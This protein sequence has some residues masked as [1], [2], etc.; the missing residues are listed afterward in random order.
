MA[1]LI[2]IFSAGK[3]VDLFYVIAEPKYQETI[4][5][6]LASNGCTADFL[7]VSNSMDKAKHIVNKVFN[8]LKIKVPSLFRPVGPL[9]L[10]EFLE[11]LMARDFISTVC[12]TPE[13]RRKI[14]EK[15]TV[16]GQADTTTM[17]DP[18]SPA[19]DS[20]FDDDVVNEIARLENS[21]NALDHSIMNQPILDAINKVNANL[22]AQNRLMKDVMGEVK[23]LKQ[24][25]REI[26]VVQEKQEFILQGIQAKLQIEPTIWCHF[27]KI[28]SHNFQECKLK[29][30]CIFCA[31]EFHSADECIWKLM[32]CS[33]CGEQGHSNQVHHVKEPALRERI[34]MCHGKRKFSFR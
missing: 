26:K 27:C 4:N 17:V 29:E 20:S 34:R 30:L 21:K 1:A 3:P 10:I 24:E 19:F 33:E 22:E 32:R 23:D 31:T 12:V 16:N 18:P 15:S 6:Y 11:Q 2:T 7:P 9:S 5:S 8:N 13:I 14:K 25:V 28:S